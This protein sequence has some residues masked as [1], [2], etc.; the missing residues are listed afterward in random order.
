MKKLFFSFLLLFSFSITFAKLDYPQEY[1]SA[2]T[3]A[4][5][6]WITTQTTIDNANMYWEIS[7]IELAKMISNYAMHNLRKQKSSFDTCSYSD[8]SE[9]LDDKY[10]NWVTNA[11]QLWLMWQWINEFRP[12]DKVTKAEFW[13]IL[14]RLL[15]WGA[16]DWWHPYYV[17]HLKKLNFE[18]IVSDIDDADVKNESRG[19]VM[20]MLKRSV[21]WGN[22]KI[23]L[24]AY[25]AEWFNIMYWY[26]SSDMQ[27]IKWENN[28]YVSDKYWFIFRIPSELN[29]W[30]IIHKTWET[31]DAIY[32]YEGIQDEGYNYV[33]TIF[34]ST[35]PDW[36]VKCEAENNKYCFDVWFSKWFDKYTYLKDFIPFDI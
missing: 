36:D 23:A 32:F 20:V 7:R 17:K 29:W 27:Y 1:K 22:A 4:F 28:I 24:K 5:N 12:Y 6:N 16:Y 3:R 13:T 8:I 10:D 11:C 35:N 34:A 9:K 30:F 2:Y 21:E 15:Y 18:W 33:L 14:S 25:E 26:N 19:N 31:C